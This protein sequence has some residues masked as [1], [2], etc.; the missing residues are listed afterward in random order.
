MSYKRFDQ[1]QLSP[2]TKQELLD[3]ITSKEVRR[4]GI[5]KNALYGLYDGYFYNDLLERCKEVSVGL[6]NK[7]EEITD[8]I[9]FS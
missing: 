6:K 4:N 7:V 1:T 3:L 2:E 9:E 8:T 5:L